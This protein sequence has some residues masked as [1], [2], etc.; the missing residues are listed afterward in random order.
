LKLLTEIIHLKKGSY[1]FEANAN[2]GKKLVITGYIGD[3]ENNS[4]TLIRNL[5][6]YKSNSLTIDINSYGGDAVEGLAI[7]NAL[8]KWKAENKA[9]IIVNITGY[10]M[11]AATVI[12]MAGDE[13]NM[14]ENGIFMIHNPSMAG[15]EKDKWKAYLQDYASELSQIAETDYNI[16][17]LLEKAYTSVYVKETGLSEEDVK[18]MMAAETW[19]RGNDAMSK[20]FATKVS[21]TAELEATACANFKNIPQDLKAIFKEPEEDQSNFLNQFI[22]EMKD[23]KKTITAFLATLKSKGVILASAEGK[24][25]TPEQVQD[26]SDSIAASIEAETEAEKPEAVSKQDFEAFKNG[27]IKAMTD[28]ITALESA[29]ETL[30][31]E[32][33]K[34]QG[35]PSGT[36]SA[37]NPVSGTTTP[38]V[39]D[40][41]EKF[42]SSYLSKRGVTK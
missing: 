19:L 41:S 29:N 22:D 9:T 21:G 11:S 10:A 8:N 28:K 25:Q 15:M 4:Q 36:P 24:E 18:A 34:A 42:L 2:G 33:A 38:P 31:A 16:L 13:V 5:E 27:T 17:N 40:E 32:L 35:K 6:A 14:P 26:L 39:A 3:W 30:T 23:V 20:G 7:Y 12:A 37:D 1:K